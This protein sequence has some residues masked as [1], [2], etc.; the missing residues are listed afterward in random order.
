MAKLNA[1]YYDIETLDNVFTNS[2]F[3]E[4]NGEAYVFYLIDGGDC[5]PPILRVPYGGMVGNQFADGC[6]ARIW[7]KNRNFRGTVSCL[8]LSCPRCMIMMASLTG[9]L[10]P[11]ADKSALFWS[12]AQWTAE[13]DG[14]EYPYYHEFL[15][16]SDGGYLEDERAYFFGYNSFNYD[17]TV[18]AYFYAVRFGI[19]FS[20]PAYPNGRYF[21]SDEK[22]TPYDIRRFSDQLFT[23][24]FQKNMPSALWSFFDEMSGITVWNADSEGKAIRDRMIRSGRHIDVA[25]LNE[26]Q[27]KTALKR[28]LGLIGR[29]VL[30]SDKLGPAVSHV[31]NSDE[32][33]D[34]IAYNISD[35][36]NL[37]E[38][39]HH[40]LYMS[41]FELKRSLL[42][43]YPDLIY[44]R[45]EDR[46]EP[47][48]RPEAV[49]PMRQRI[50]SSSSQ[51]ASHILCPYDNLGDY[52]NVSYMYPSSAEGDDSGMV[53]I[54]KETEEF[55]RSMYPPS[56][57][58]F[59]IANTMF[60]RVLDFYRKIEGKNFNGSERH[61]ADFP[62]EPVWSLSGKEDD[63]YSAT[64]RDKG[65][66]LPYF[67][68]EG[69]PTSCYVVFS[70]GGIHGAE[71]N[72]ELFEKDV[73]EY[74]EAAAKTEAAKKAIENLIRSEHPELSGDDV[75]DGMTAARL[76][77][78][79]T[80]TLED[81]SK[82]GWKEF[83]K[84]GATKKTAEWKTV[85]KPVLF[86]DGKMKLNSKYAYTSAGLA[87]HADF[88]S[89]YPV[90]LD[91]MHAFH[92][93]SLGEDRYHDIF[94][95]KEEHGKRMKDGSLTEAERNRYAVMREGTKLVLNSASGAA[96]A[97]FDNPILMNNRII[98]MRIIGQ[99][100]TWRIGQALAHEG[101]RI[102][103]TNTDG[104]YSMGIPAETNNAI[105]AKEAEKIRVEIEPEPCWLV[106]KDSNNRLE[107][108]PSTFEIRSASGGSLACWSG[109]D[110]AKA[111][112]HPAAMDRILAEYLI[113]ASRNGK[114]AE[115]YDEQKGM[116]IVINIRNT[117]KKIDQLLLFQNILAASSM[118]NTYHYAIRRDGSIYPLQRYNRM[119]FVGDRKDDA[120]NIKAATARKPTPAM[121]DKRLR[122][123]DAPYQREEQ[124]LAI[125]EANAV[126][127]EKYAYRDVVSK[128]VEFVEENDSVIIDNGPVY[129]YT[130]EEADAILVRLDLAK[131]NRLVMEHFEK[132][133]KNANPNN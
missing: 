18:L 53:N 129:L 10:D 122:E 99:L 93:A 37:K 50:D 104:L 102:V 23:D 41:S 75:T 81:G 87:Q 48:V 52:K 72:R 22:I 82:A 33:F 109:P 66:F 86:D 79:G 113:W 3:C 44:Q 65:V 40:P 57:Q 29:Q 13:T 88:K 96:D 54:L 42:K 14:G 115:A 80:V 126:S 28:V 117:E 68:S 120:V 39:M 25:R 91:N 31:K 59:S 100:F 47:D 95:K 56:D 24:E 63:Y 55:F 11:A 46:Y 124:A 121:T 119:F 74:A 38:L 36:V 98:S 132:N 7:E 105:V 84:S 118:S 27:Q 9:G 127:P 45:K 114:M 35:V 43:E 2:F 78:D 32:L 8:N 116:E 34:L 76:R 112:P 83:L 1:Y 71:Y 6:A 5:L 15:W 19:D 101:A 61:F 60:D 110:P 26:K 106:S 89:Y 20:D 67:D 125:F 103:S 90:M 16:T 111:L 123:G 73:A 128:K 85:R 4:S 77:C 51:L 17:T 58:R 133:W 107:A 130:D 12:D 62:D 97:K 69:S 92:N 131:Y 108:D 49:N 30:E 70:T 64:G 21:L 94:L